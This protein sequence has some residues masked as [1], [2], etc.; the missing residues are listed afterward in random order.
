MSNDKKY[1]C[2]D[3]GNYYGDIPVFGCGYC[4]SENYYSTDNESNACEDEHAL[5]VGSMM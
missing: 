1:Q 2:L 5:G 3:C 4:H